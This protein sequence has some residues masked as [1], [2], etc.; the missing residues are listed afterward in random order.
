VA[1]MSYA[2]IG[3]SGV[4][5]KVPRNSEPVLSPLIGLATRLINGAT[6]IFL[7]DAIKWSLRAS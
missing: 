5:F 4:P 3:P 2:L 1:L 7:D 6:G